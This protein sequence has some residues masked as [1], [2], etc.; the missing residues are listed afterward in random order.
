MSFGTALPPVDPAE[1]PGEL[2]AHVRTFELPTGAVI[3]RMT[4]REHD[5]DGWCVS[6]G[7]EWYVYADG[8]VAERP[9]WRALAEMGMTSDDDLQGQPD[10]IWAAYSDAKERF[11]RQMLLSISEA[12]AVAV[13]CGAANRLAVKDEPVTIRKTGERGVISDPGTE[14]EPGHYVRVKLDASGEERVFPLRAI[15]YDD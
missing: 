4:A 8:T 10:E 2:L 11:A 3:K 1:I 12:F 9:A 6:L 5:L 7:P 13:A 15:A 14:H